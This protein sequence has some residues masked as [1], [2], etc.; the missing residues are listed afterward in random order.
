M[1]SVISFLMIDKA[2]KAFP[3]I[4]P[5]CQDFSNISFRLK[6]WSVVGLLRP[7]QK[8]HELSS[9]LISLFLDISFQGIWLFLSN[10][11]MIPLFTISFP[12]YRNNHTCLPISG[13]FVKFPRNLTHSCLPENSFFNQG[14][15]RFGSADFIF[16]SSFF[17]FYPLIAVATSTA[18]KFHFS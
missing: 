5:L 8:P 17:R 10:Q 1:N 7:V 12:E 15:H 9:V 16:T 2:Y 11:E 18:G 13:S 6:I 4:F 3:W 14:F